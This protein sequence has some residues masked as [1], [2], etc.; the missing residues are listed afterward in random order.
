MCN[1]RDAAPGG[2]RRWGSIGSGDDLAGAND[3]VVDSIP[4]VPASGRPKKG[5][6]SL[7][8]TDYNSYGGPASP[9]P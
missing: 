2:P 8:A 7:P 6:A 3:K 5:V 9:Q 4:H 1:G